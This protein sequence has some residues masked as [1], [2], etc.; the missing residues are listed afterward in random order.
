MDTESQRLSVQRN[1]GQAGKDTERC[2]REAERHRWCNLL[3]RGAEDV[4]RLARRVGGGTDPG[5]P[6]CLQIRCQKA[7]VIKEH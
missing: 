1:S 4:D 5:E 3:A 2:G 7:T 6:V